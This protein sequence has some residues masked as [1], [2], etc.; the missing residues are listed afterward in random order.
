MIEAGKRFGNYEI[1]SL[2]GTGG[3]G[4]VYLAEDIRLNRKVAVKFLNPELSKNQE[5]LHRFIRE[6]RAASALNH[7]NILTVHDIGQTDDANFIATEFVEGESLRE[8][9]AENQNELIEVLDISLQIASALAAAHEAGIVHR[10]IKPE[11]IMIRRDGL[12]KI[13]DFG[14]AKLTEKRKANAE[15][16]TEILANTAPGMIMGTPNYMSPEQARGKETDGRTDIWSFG[17]MLYGMLTRR[18]PFAGET[19]GDVIA[20]ILKSEPE[21]LGKFNLEIPPELER[22]VSKMLAKDREDRYQTAK[23]LQIDLKRL[24]K[25]IELGAEIKIDTPAKNQIES[26]GENPTQILVA[27]PTLKTGFVGELKRRKIIFAMI[28]LTVLVGIIGA[29]AWRFNKS[30]DKSETPSNIAIVTDSPKSVPDPIK[31]YWQ[32]TEAEQL[33]FILERA[34][35]IQTLIGDEPTEFDEEALR[36]IKVEIDYYVEKKDNLSQKPFEEGMRVIYGRASQYAPTI[37]RAYEA[38]QIAPVLGLYQAMVESEYHDCLTSPIGSVGLFQFQPETAREYGL[39]PKDYCNVEKQADAAA[40][41]MSNLTSDFGNGKS[42][43]T[44]G[45]LG[46]VI[47]ENAVRKYLRQ[48]R[49]RGVTEQNFWVIF[50]YRNDFK[51]PLSPE[52]RRYLPRF[53]AA[54]IIGETPKE[55]ELSTPPLTTLR[56]SRK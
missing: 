15:D 48:L 22:I 7:P 19:M 55:F 28:F 33:A 8:R 30:D 3:M 34:R 18:L 51:E 5:H 16:E 35:H 52:G 23:D 54:A 43:A 46:F 32:M 45:L 11:N 13:L 49:E 1:C 14:L 17:V 29:L 42:S 4:E 6:A 44:L 37:T 40:R 2:L 21:P 25:Q 27:Q 50:R 26:G 38:R 36:A 56:E 9:F 53:F 39:M 41:Y 24:R 47:G 12:V 20:A 31:F 10:D